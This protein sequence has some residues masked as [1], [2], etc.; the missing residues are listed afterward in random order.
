MHSQ[1]ILL[2]SNQMPGQL[3]NQIVVVQSTESSTMKNLQAEHMPRYDDPKV[4]GD[5]R[6]RLQH[7]YVCA[8]LQM[9]VHERQLHRWLQ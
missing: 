9:L 2:T 6:A 1:V 8:L 5:V 7:Q 3:Q 4:M